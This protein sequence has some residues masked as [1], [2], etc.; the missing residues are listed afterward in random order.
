MQWAG[1]CVG[2]CLRPSRRMWS[3]FQ[4][5]T[6][7]HVQV[8]GPLSSSADRETSH[9]HCN[10]VSSCY[11][12]NRASFPDYGASN[13]RPMVSVSHMATLV[14]D[15]HSALKPCSWWPIEK[16][17]PLLGHLWALMDLAY[18]M[19][20]SRPKGCI[21]KPALLHSLKAGG[22]NVGHG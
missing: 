9:R 14:C 8:L 7:R 15:K 1:E 21:P 13:D 12:H 4:G 3:S 18:R 16:L 2:S 20:A 10:I 5:L 19:E 11:T 6:K 22:T 17:E